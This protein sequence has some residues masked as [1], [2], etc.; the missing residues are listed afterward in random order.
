MQTTQS[1]P[2]PRPRMP[3]TSALHQARP[4]RELAKRAGHSRPSMSLDVYSHV[5]PVD[6]APAERLLSSTRAG[7]VLA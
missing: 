7:G 2:R 1:T 6:E 3:I 4:A 5:M